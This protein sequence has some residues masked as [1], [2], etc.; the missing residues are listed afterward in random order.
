MIRKYIIMILVTFTSVSYG[1]F[2]DSFIWKNYLSR[3]E[4]NSRSFLSSDGEIKLMFLH[5]NIYGIESLNWNFVSMSYDKGILGFGMDVSA[6]GYKEY[7]QRN[8][9][10]WRIKYRPHNNIRIA[11]AIEILTEEFHNFGRHTGLSGEFY[12]NYIQDKFNVGLGFTELQLIKPYDKSFNEA[13]KPFVFGSWVFDEGLTLSIGIR[14]FENKRTRWIFDQF[15]A[16]NDKLG[17]NFGYKNNPSDIY[18]GVDL[19]INRF[20]FIITFSSVDGLRD[21][22]VWGISFRG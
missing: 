11:P 13:L 9:Y 5:S 3:P 15:V 10:R 4:N 16:V 19:T 6:V 12:I 14:R 8:K 1:G 17:L 2:D 20:T 18:G 7:Y 21:S 22:I